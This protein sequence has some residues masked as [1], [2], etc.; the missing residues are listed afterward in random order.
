MNS[1]PY[2]A[3]CE[4]CNTS[5]VAEISTI[6]RHAEGIKHKYKMK[7]LPCS[8]GMVQ[9][10]LRNFFV[11]DNQFEDQVKELEISLC[12]FIAEHNIPYRAVDHLSKLLK[13]KIP[14]SK[15]VK[16]I[17]LGRT[18]AR[19]IITN[20]IGT[21]HKDE[22]SEKLKRSKFSVLV[23]E[24]TDIATVKQMCVVIR[25]FDSERL[26]I[27]TYFWELVPVQNSTA[28]SMFNAIIQTFTEKN[29][30][31]TNIFSFGSDGCNVMMGRNNSV[32]SRFME[33]C[34]GI[35]IVKCICHSLHICASEACK[36]LPRSIEDLA[37]DIYAFF[38]VSIY[39]VFFIRS[40]T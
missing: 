18:K 14:D 20:V 30:S 1:N 5:L 3:F 7:N 31:L 35:K 27:E 2:N 25:F 32:Y 4:C 11:Q 22:L 37:R 16:Y 13:N 21:T 33:Q 23:D 12:G 29:V 8:S 26:K 17:N 38:K 15:L 6:K 28:E 34:P 40:L 39:H 36:V 24:S 19:G 10:K 9:P